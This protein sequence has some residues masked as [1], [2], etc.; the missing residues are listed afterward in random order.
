[1]KRRTRI[2]QAAPAF[3]VLFGGLA[4][5]MRENPVPRDGHASDPVIAA[6]GDIAD[7]GGRQR[8]TSALLLDSP[9]GGGG[10]SGTAGA[11]STLASSPLAAILAL[12][13]NQYE[14]GTL[15]EYRRLYEPT[16]GRLKDKTYP[17]PGN[18]EYGVPLAA[19]YFDY[20][21]PRAGPRGKGYYSF[22]VGEWHLIALNSEIAHERF[23]IEHPDPEEEEEEDEDTNGGN[24]DEDEEIVL[25]A[26]ESDLRRPSAQ[27][28]WLRKDLAATDA[29]CV[30]AYWHRP[31]FSSGDHGGYESVH[32]FWEALYEA[33]A[34]LVLVAHDHDYERFAPM[35]P[36]GRR[37]PERGIRQFVVGTGGTLNQEGFDEIHSN[38]EV[39][40]SQQWGVLKLRLNPS[41]YR[42]EFQPAQGSTFRDSGIGECH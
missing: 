22:D 18:H 20:F 39:R 6:A 24:D 37:D 31:R 13:D 8:E 4:C 3:A 27:L 40:A 2:A 34:D 26:S 32:P 5:A 9:P 33:N 25:D 16:W 42:W 29:K 14:D 41:S 17:V 38:S 30:L 36:D 10:R 15:A 21:G 11:D 35:S 28:E 1:M 12:G 7:P 23:G 19:G